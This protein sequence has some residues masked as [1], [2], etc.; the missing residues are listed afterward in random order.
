MYVELNLIDMKATLLKRYTRPDGGLSRRRGNMQTLSNNNVL[1]C[2]SARGYTSEF[3]H[4]GKLLM[5]AKFASD[6]FS[7]YRAY[8]LDGWWSQPANPPTLVASWYGVNGS[9]YSTVF[10][11]S[12]N[13]ATE[14]RYWRFFAQAGNATRRQEVS[15]VPKTGFETSFISRGYLDWVSVEA[16]DSQK[17]VLDS[18]P[19]VR[20]SSPEFWEGEKLPT[21]DDPATLDKD[22]SEIVLEISTAAG[23]SVALFI[24]GTLTSGGC[25]A[26]FFFY[27]AIRQ[28]YRQRYWRVRQDGCLDSEALEGEGLLK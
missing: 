18:S 1:A 21:P 26:L 4:A 6:R 7:T 17:R 22:T 13:G 11:V 27:P 2:W 28:Y 9:E 24:A 16:L 20:T 12:W 5:D 8:K 15:T 23:V 3:S 10:Y 14:V 19:T 25:Y